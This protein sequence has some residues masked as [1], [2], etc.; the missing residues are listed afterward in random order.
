MINRVDQ[1][2]SKPVTLPEAHAALT[3]RFEEL[4][5]LD[6]SMTP[7]LGTC[8]LCHDFRLILQLY[9]RNGLTVK[10]AALSSRLSSRG[11]YEL[12]RRLERDKVLRFEQNPTDKR[13]KSIMLE[14]TFKDR[15]LSHIHR[16]SGSASVFQFS[17][18]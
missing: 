14:E 6:R 16:N 12:L 7:S 1:A 10:D 11:F 3:A 5:E 18:A 4:L 15:L 13:S 2:S 9:V 8:F 17:M